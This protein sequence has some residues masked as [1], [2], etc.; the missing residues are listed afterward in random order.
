MDE[1]LI[2]IEVTNIMFPLFGRKSLKRLLLSLVFL[3]FCFAPTPVAQA[4]G[5]GPEPGG[6]FEMRNVPP[7]RL[8]R[9]RMMPGREMGRARLLA[10]L[11]RADVQRELGITAEQR[12]KLEEIVFSTRKATI[13]ERAN[14]ETHRL[15]LTRLMRAENPD[16]A[17]INKKLQ[18]VS[19][20]RLALS[21]SLVNGLLDGRAVLTKEQHDKITQFLQRRLTERVRGGTPEPGP[22]RPDGRTPAPPRRNEPALPPLRP[23]GT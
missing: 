19:D 4:Q 21:R 15:E 13:Q 8:E 2:G 9:R 6:R 3:S 1:I 18:E 7:R 10:F 17:A 11:L 5:D 14:L 23:P 20:A 22:I 16:R 12:K